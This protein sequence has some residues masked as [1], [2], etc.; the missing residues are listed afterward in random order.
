MDISTLDRSLT[1]TGAAGMA[2]G[3]DLG[4]TWSKLAWRTSRTRPASSNSSGGRPCS[5][6]TGTAHRSPIAPDARS[7]GVVVRPVHH[8]AGRIKLGA[9]QSGV[10]WPNGRH[11]ARG[12]PDLRAPVGSGAVGTDRGHAKILAD[13]VGRWARHS[14]PDRRPAEIARAEVPARPGERSDRGRRLFRIPV[15]GTGRRR[16]DAAVRRRSPDVY[17]IALLHAIRSGAP[18]ADRQSVTAAS[19]AYPVP[20]DTFVD[21]A[22]REAAARADRPGDS[23]AR[24]SS[25]RSPIP[26]PNAATR[27]SMRPRP[28]QLAR[29]RGV[30]L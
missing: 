16:A 23:F 22:L 24:C 7:A 1:D 26:V 21:W 6:M 5:A 15:P 25:G 9:G 3:L 14:R 10:G 27:Y 18:E 11:R 28:T 20:L 12:L 17:R 2:A 13:Q 4:A 30:R 29:Y 19:Q 8:P